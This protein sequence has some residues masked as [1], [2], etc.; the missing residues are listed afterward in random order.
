LLVATV[1]FSSLFLFLSTVGQGAAVDCGVEEEEETAADEHLTPE[2]IVMQKKSELENSEDFKSMNK[3]Q[4][5]KALQQWE[6]E[7]EFYLKSLQKS[8]KEVPTESK[9]IG[10]KKVQKKNVTGGHNR[11]FRA[12][13]QKKAVYGGKKGKTADESGD[14]D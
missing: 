7:N 9:V 1:P 10:P 14:S 11:E 12:P 2:G 4:R 3:T 6:A 5:R 8:G 13:K